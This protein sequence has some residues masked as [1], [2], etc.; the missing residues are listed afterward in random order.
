MSYRLRSFNL[1]NAA[2]ESYGVL[3]TD[4]HIQGLSIEVAPAAVNRVEQGKPYSSLSASVFLYERRSS[5]RLH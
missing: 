1:Q 4:I 2:S 3:S 5:L